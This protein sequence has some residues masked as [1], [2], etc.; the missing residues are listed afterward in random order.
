MRDTLDE[1]LKDN[2]R[3]SQKVV[4]GFA[5]IAEQALKFI[6]HLD[7]GL[8]IA[9]RSQGGISATNRTRPILPLLGLVQWNA[10]CFEP[11]PGYNLWALDS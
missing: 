6:K 2:W 8:A 5:D 9:E 4:D 10:P 3:I 7:A 1:K 11:L